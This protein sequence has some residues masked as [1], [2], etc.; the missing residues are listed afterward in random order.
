VLLTLDPEKISMV[1]ALV[2]SAACT[3]EQAAE[4]ARFKAYL[5]REIDGVNTRLARVQTV[6]KFAILPAELSVDGGEL[7]PT[8][9]V[10][11]KV[12]SQKYAS[13]IDRLYSDD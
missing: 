11:R 5:Q 2:E 12:V 4:C 8:M 7:T 13:V 1:A 3:P 9:K 6:K 10:K